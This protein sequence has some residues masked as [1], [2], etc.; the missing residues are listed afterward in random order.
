[1]TR[2]SPAARP[3][4][5]PTRSG[6]ATRSGD[7]AAA[8]L[9]RT[10]AL[11]G[12]AIDR[13]AHRRTDPEW[14]DAAWRRCRVV[15]VDDNRALV[16]GEPPRLVL[17]GP[18]D[19]PEGDRLF[20]G[21]DPDAVPY[22]AVAAVLA[23]VDGARPASLRGVGA[24]LS[25]RD[26]DLFVA[27]AGLANWHLRYG[28]SPATGTPTRIGES[29]WVRTADD[30]ALLF[31]RTDPAVIM[32]VTDGEGG[33]DG[34][35]LLGR[36]ASWPEGRYSCLAGFVE[37]GESAEATVAREVAEEV[38]LPVREVRY[39]TSQPWPYPGSLMLAFRALGDPGQP[40]SVDSAELAEARWFTRAELRAMWAGR[41][42]IRTSVAYTLMAGWL[43]ES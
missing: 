27:A 19:A 38:G 21:V 29:G 28:Y 3:A 7:P 4:G 10:A 14:L 6:A 17:I 34:R 15:V 20:L 33:E 13:A 40:L 16:T 31:P 36:G 42:P 41:T 37:P 5:T 1:M 12:Q 11:V 2:S 35:C 8:E 26:I 18:G 25:P 30:N 9:L 22:F 24:D 23:T 39:V 32:L 43:A